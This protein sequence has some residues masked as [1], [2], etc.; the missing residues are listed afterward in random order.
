MGDDKNFCPEPNSKRRKLE[1]ESDLCSDGAESQSSGE[2][3]STG[4]KIGSKRSSSVL[5]DT[6]PP[7]MS[8]NARERDRTHSVNSAFVTLRT[9]IPTE[10]ADRKLSKIEVLRLSASYIAHLNTLLMVGSEYVDQPC[11]KHQAMM[12]GS[13]GVDA[14]PKPVCTFCLSA[15]RH[16]TTYTDCECEFT[17]AFEKHYCVAYMPKNQFDDWL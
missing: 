8:A 17:T 3:Q 11:I 15:S 5:S 9:M 14:M 4:T 6:K 1:N 7:R 12:R 10:P 2:D 13:L 16:R